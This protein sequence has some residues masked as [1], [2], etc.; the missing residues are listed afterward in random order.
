MR[1]VEAARECQLISFS[2]GKSHYSNSISVTK[3]KCASQ[4]DRYYSLCVHGGVVTL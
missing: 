3:I 4:S 2:E 1:E